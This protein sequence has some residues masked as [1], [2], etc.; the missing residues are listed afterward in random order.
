M[1]IK[2]DQS[3]S[4]NSRTILSNLPSETGL[5]NA[6]V[7]HK[8]RFLV[9]LYDSSNNKLDKGGDTVVAVLLDSGLNPAGVIDVKDNNDG[10]Y[11]VEYYIDTLYGT[12][13]CEV[14]VNG[15]SAN[16]KTT[17]IYVTPDSPFALSSTISHPAVITVGTSSLIDVLI[18]D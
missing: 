11:I 5:T 16:K 10:T 17:T 13:T 1:D 18:K 9:T 8:A 7:G 3:S 14:T 2:V 4:D 12:Y 6:I 15:D